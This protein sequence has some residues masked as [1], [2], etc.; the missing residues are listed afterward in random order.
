[1]IKCDYCEKTAIAYACYECIPY[2]KDHLK[3]AKETATKMFKFLEE[4]EEY[5]EDK[6]FEKARK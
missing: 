6:Y 2:C 5:K 4:Y 3:E 1:M